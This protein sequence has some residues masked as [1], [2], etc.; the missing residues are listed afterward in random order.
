MISAKDVE[1][2]DVPTPSF[3]TKLRM[4]K[5]AKGTA[6]AGYQDLNAENHDHSDPYE[7]RRCLK[8]LDERKTKIAS[9]QKI[10]KAIIGHHD[11]KNKKHNTH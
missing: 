1:Q 5:A 10:C 11:L 7:I 3:A 2:D 9:V 8:L 6:I 4:A